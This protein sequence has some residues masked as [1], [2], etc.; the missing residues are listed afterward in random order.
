MIIPS[1]LSDIQPRA[2]QVCNWDEVGFGPNV[3]W[4]KVICTYKLFQGKQMW[5]V[6]TGKQAPLWCTL[7]VFNQADGQCFVPPITVHQA[8]YYSQDI[9][10]NVPLDCTVHHTPS[11]YMDR[12]VWIKYM[13]QF[14]NV[15]LA[16][17]IN[18][19]ILLFNGHGSHFDNGTLRKMMCRNIQPF[20]LK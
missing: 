9:Q 1:D 16:S 18:N 14:Y 11:G 13:T 10:S 2:T 19:H 4:N 5:K 6:K 12:Y 20:V 8:N 15:C 17:P 7:L 3:I